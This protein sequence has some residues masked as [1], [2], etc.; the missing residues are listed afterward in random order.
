[1]REFSRNISGWNEQHSNATL[2]GVDTVFWRL[3]TLQTEGKADKA[4][5][6][7]IIP[8]MKWEFLYSNNEPPLQVTFYSRPK[9]SKQHWVRIATDG[10]FYPVH[11][12]AINE[13]LGLLPAPQAI[14]LN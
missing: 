12:G 10:P 2:V 5:P 6:E 8:V 1:M 9:E 4:V 14:K 13:I 11:T 7:D 3:G